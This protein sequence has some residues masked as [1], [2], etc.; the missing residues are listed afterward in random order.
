M[1]KIIQ[2]VSEYKFI[3]K[4]KHLEL[5]TDKNTAVFEIYGKTE[6]FMVHDAYW[7]TES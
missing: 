7:T 1:A 2:L 6:G 4:I 5:K 3:E